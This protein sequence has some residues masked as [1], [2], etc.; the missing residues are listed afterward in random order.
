MPAN[1]ARKESTSKKSPHSRD[2]VQAR[3]REAQVLELRKSGA[4][5][6]QMAKM[7]GMTEE[8][9]RRVLKRALEGLRQV[10]EEEGPHVRDLELARLDT[11]LVGT[12]DRARKGDLGA[13]KTVLSIMQQRA[14]YIPGLEV[15]SRAEVTGANGGPLVGT[16]DAMVLLQRFDAID[17][18]VETRAALEAKLAAA[19]VVEPTPS[20]S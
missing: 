4:S 8:G 14:R 9:C 1:A 15:P 6:R 20:E 5:F 12:W 16:A 7:L 11:M 13:V 17:K 2:L 18:A 3:E 10:V 19:T